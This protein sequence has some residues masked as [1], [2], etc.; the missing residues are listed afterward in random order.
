MYM[1]N[2]YIVRLEKFRN[3]VIKKIYRGGDEE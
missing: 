1:N 3:K 2:C